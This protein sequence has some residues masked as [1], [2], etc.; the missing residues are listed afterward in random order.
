LRPQQA[1][2]GGGERG[3][4]MS[5]RSYEQHPWQQVLGGFEPAALLNNYKVY[6][7][8][9]QAIPFVDV[10]LRKFSRLVAGFH[11]T[12]EVEAT[13]QA[14]DVFLEQVRCNDI[15]RGFRAFEM[16]HVN[17]LLQY[18][19]AIGEIVPTTTGRD[20]YQLMPIAPAKVRLQRNDAGE[21]V[22]GEED[23]FGGFREY[24]H[25]ELLLYNVIGGEIDN[26]FGVS[27]LRAIPF[28][29]ETMLMMENAIKQQWRRQGAPAFVFE[30]R[31]PKEAG[32]TPEQLKKR[33]AAVRKAVKLWAQRGWEK[34]GVMDFTISTQGEF[35]VT[36]LGADA[37]QLEY[38]ETLRSLEE[39]IV[40]SIELAPFLL[41]LQWSTTE[42]LSQQQADAIIA[43]V[44]DV[45]AEVGSDWM[46]VLDWWQRLTGT[47]GEMVVN[48]EPVMLQDVV[49]TAR[50]E[51]MQ[52][53]A[54]V[55][56]TEAAKVA[57]DLGWVDQLGAA[58]IAG[59][60]IDEPARPMDEPP[61]APAPVAGGAGNLPAGDETFAGA[62]RR[63]WADYPAAG[64]SE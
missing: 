64:G 47:Q 15:Q 30:D 51:F 44:D 10:G 2:D 38:K 3:E 29:A 11:V 4:P 52:A 24:E 22:I 48:W 43:A 5:L 32:L 31:V 9:R 14:V 26:L 13:Q 21:I 19:R 8:I 1:D 35:I 39:Q 57:W 58:E 56:R 41:G 62:A 17:A 54:M 33:E 59:H 23:G 7:A 25:Q 53:Q 42:R 18:G 36:T 16:R 55:K 12:C 27:L 40:A 50:A 28:V 49:E 61:S 6:D 63:W 20:I 34:Q 46:R 60:D 45:R 37:K